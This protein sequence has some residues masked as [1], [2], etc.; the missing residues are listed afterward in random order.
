MDPGGEPYKKRPDYQEAQ[1][2]QEDLKLLPDD[3]RQVS[4]RI[5]TQLLNWIRERDDDGSPFKL[6]N[7]EVLA[8]KLGA[9]R[10]GLR[11][12]LT[13]MESE[14]YITRRRGIGT[15]VNPRIARNRTRLDLQMEFGT[16]IRDQGYVFD[17]E[18]LEASFIPE[19]LECFEEDES[20]HL[21]ISK[22]CY[23]DN[24][25]VVYIEDRLA[26]SRAAAGEAFLKELRTK[27]LSGFI[28]RRLCIQYAYSFSEL[29]AVNPSAGIARLLKMDPHLPVLQLSDIDFDYDHRPYKHSS[30]FVRTDVIKLNLLRRS[31]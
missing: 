6:P 16:L 21:L 5:R 10:T 18:L 25:P 7:E 26:G 11:D 15:L 20:R 28:V 23:A 29:K 3:R 27:S 12:A 8:R 9:S 30:V 24:Q 22:I 17:F 19:N 4:K 31:L 14:G 2:S 13:V 1:V